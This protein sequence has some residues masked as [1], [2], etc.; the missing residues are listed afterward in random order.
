MFEP[1]NAP[2]PG[3]RR[4]TVILAQSFSISM[5]DAQHLHL[6][7]IVD[8]MTGRRVREELYRVSEMA[9]D[10]CQ[11]LATTLPEPAKAVKAH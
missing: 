10:I 9:P 3:V 8:N 4:H 7:N 1:W 5:A 2:K 6:S 11:R